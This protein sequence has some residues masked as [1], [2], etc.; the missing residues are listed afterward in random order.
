MCPYHIKR[1]Y[2]T[3]FT[4][5]IRVRWLTNKHLTFNCVLVTYRPQLCFFFFFD[6]QYSDSTCLKVEYLHVQYKVKLKREKERSE[7]KMFVRIKAQ[8]VD[9]F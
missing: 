6:L 3:V 7:Y 8:A 1:K 9:G 5:Y 2:G 4:L